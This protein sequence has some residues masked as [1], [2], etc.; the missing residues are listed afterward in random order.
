MKFFEESVE[1]AFRILF[2]GASEGIVVVNSEQFIVATNAS[3]RGIFGYDKEELEG[4]HL[5]TLIPTSYHKEHHSHFNDFMKHSQKREMGKG[6]VL[7]GMRK[8]GSQFPVEAGLNPFSLHEHHYVMALVTDITVR[9][10]QEKHIEDLNNHLEE[11]IEERTDSLNKAIESLQEEVVLRKEAERSANEALQKE[12]ELNE[13]KTKFLSLVSHE[14]KTPISGILTS[15]TLASKYTKEEHQEKRVKHLDTIKS[16]VKYLNTII[17]DFL[18]IERL[19]T[20]KTNYKISSFPL[21]KVLNEVI[22]DAN[23]HLK[24]GQTI[25]YPKNADDITLEFDEKILELSLSN[26]IHN[27]VKYSGEQ[28]IV[29]LRIIEKVNLLEIQ[30]KDQG[31]GIPEHEQ[32]F[33][34]DRYF[35]AENVLLNPGTGIGLNIVQNHLKNLGSTISFQSKENEGSTFIISIPSK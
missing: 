1:E 23:V 21:S 35:R 17:D 22:Y 6:R 24:E 29:D 3:A 11:K 32:R 10:A 18:S 12:K 31:I 16:K 5:H 34:F 20:G 7:Y 27:A 28:T 4:Q 14:F 30:I 2:E 9:K 33:I 8:D 25:S 15:A 19:D 26:L 13:L